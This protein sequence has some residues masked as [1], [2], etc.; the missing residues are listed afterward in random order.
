MSPLALSP[1]FCENC[2]PRHKLEK[3]AFSLQFF[4]VRSD[5]FHSIIF[6]NILG[7]FF[8]FFFFFVSQGKGEIKSLPLAAPC[9]QILQCICIGSNESSIEYLNIVKIS[10][11]LR[12]KPIISPLWGIS[13]S[14]VLRRMSPSKSVI[15]V[16]MTNISISLLFALPRGDDEQNPRD[17][18]CSGKFSQRLKFLKL[19]NV[20]SFRRSFNVLHPVWC[21]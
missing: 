3:V 2:D 10:P 16:K 6:G 7:F 9:V 19:E 11:P 20:S 4:I 12:E 21:H 8:F 17:M 18:H 15:V 1:R 5:V 14:T 13:H